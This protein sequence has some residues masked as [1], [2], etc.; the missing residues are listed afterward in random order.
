MSKKIFHMLNQLGDNKTLIKKALSTASASGGTLPPEHLEQMITDTVNRLSPELAML[1]GSIKKIGSNKRRFNRITSK[2]K[3]GGAMG[4]TAVTPTNSSA[5]EEAETALKVIRRKGAVTN[6]LKD[7][8]ASRLDASAFEM[9][10]CI[11]AHV[12]D[13]CYYLH[14]GNK[15]FTKDVEFDGLEKH[16]T[17]NRTNQARGGAVP[18]SLKF[19]DDMIDKSNRKKG[20]RHKRAFKMSPE[21]LSKVS[22]L[23]TNVRLNQ[24]LSGSGL[25]QV[26]I[27]GGWRMN[28]YRDIPII[29]STQCAPTSQLSDSLITLTTASTGGSLSDATYYIQV[30]CVD[31]Y[32]EQI[33][34]TQKSITLSG[35]TSTQVIKI[36]LSSVPLDSDSIA[37]VYSYKIYAATTTGAAVLADWKSAFLYDS[38]GTITGDNGVGTGNEMILTKL[39]GNASVPSHLVGEVPLNYTSSVAPENI[40]L[41]DMDR[42][43]GLG[44]LSYVNSA[45]S[46]FNGLVTTEGLDRTDDYIQFLVKSYCALSD[47]YE[48]TTVIE[49]GYRVI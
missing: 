12:S 19:L 39:T 45:G 44:D 37:S 31:H 18:S 41:W 20:N 13:L 5:T 22:Q 8:T 4:D 9:Q 47:A 14:F 23:L 38:S 26:D 3:R 24:G 28:A 42:I 11:D 48:E 43:Q 25:T 27:G 6:F 7:A 32:G 1:E 29:E 36:A 15:D 10:N 17:T 2:P 33:A 46:A 21:M 35:G 40:I 49:R 16:V 34:S 30:A